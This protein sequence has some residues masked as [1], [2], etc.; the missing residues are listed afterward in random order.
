M[1][2]SLSSDLIFKEIF[3][4][5]KNIRFLEFMLELLK[6]LP[7][8]SLKNKVSILNGSPLNKTS[9]QNKSVTSDILVEIPGEL[10]NLE[11]YS[12]L[13][14]K[15][16]TKS[17]VY[18]FRIYSTD[19]HVGSSYKKQRKIS[20]YNF[21]LKSSLPFTKELKC[22]YLLKENNY[23]QIVAHDLKGTIYNLDKLEERKYNVGN[24]NLL[25]R[26]LL[27]IKA[28]TDEERRSIAE[29]S[30]ML[31]D[32]VTQIRKFLYD[33]ETKEM[34]NI[35]DKWKEEARDE[36]LKEGREEERKSLAKHMLKNHENVA[37]ISE[38]TG[39]SISKIQQIQKELSMS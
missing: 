13:D 15:A 29:G 6:D 28:S 20:Q 38:Y 10:I 31:M 5:Q 11:M 25:E 30:E 9:V 19:L 4:T 12:L 3:G 16:F 2:Y 1:N 33:E 26:L 17:K 34:K 7:L 27:L 37:K 22:E 24:N 18:F 8:S 36:G 21:C 32:V 35:Q 39:Y 14:D 23:N